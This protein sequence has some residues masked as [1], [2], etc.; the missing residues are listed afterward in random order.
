MQSLCERNNALWNCCVIKPDRA[1]EVL[2]VSNKIFL[3]SES[4]RAVESLTGVPWIFVGM[5]HYREADFNFG[6]S[7]AQGD[8]WASVSRHVPRGRGPFKS[9]H[10]AA[11][12][13]LIRCAPFAAKW[14]DWTP[15]GLL[16]IGEMYNGTGY[17]QYH[18]ENSPYN[19]GATNHEERGKYE[20][21]GK[22]NPA[23][24]DNQIGLA[25]ILS[26]LLRQNKEV[27]SACLQSTP[28]P[29]PG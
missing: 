28:A 15:G 20:A 9:W 4:Y 26:M 8:P 16:T 2:L 7:I 21:D 19:W 14:K 10:D 3:N 18:D 17:E 12:D 13:A 25:A 6:L 22:Y 29:L 1:H 23:A 24:W 27:I 11:V 5:V